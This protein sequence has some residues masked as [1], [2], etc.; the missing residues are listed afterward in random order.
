M[1]ASLSHEKQVII[2]IYPVSYTQNPTLYKQDLQ[3][4]VTTLAS[5][6]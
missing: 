4:I 6:D 3:G 1:V 2:Y 5:L